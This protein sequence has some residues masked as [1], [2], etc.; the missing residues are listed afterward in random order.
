MKLLEG[1]LLFFSM[2]STSPSPASPWA[3]C[4]PPAEACWASARLSTTASLALVAPC[5]RGRGKASGSVS[6]DGRE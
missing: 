5:A 1:L 6:R 4:P 2:L 3:A